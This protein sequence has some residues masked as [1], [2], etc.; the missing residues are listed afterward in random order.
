MAFPYNAPPP[1]TLCFF[2]SHELKGAV[3]GYWH[4]SPVAFAAA[5]CNRNVPLDAFVCMMRRMFDASAE[6]RLAVATEVV[7]EAARVAAVPPDPCAGDIEVV[8]HD[9]CARNA[10]E[11]RWMHHVRH[12]IPAR[13]LASEAARREM[14]SRVSQAAPG[15]RALMRAEFECALLAARSAELAPHDLHSALAIEKARVML[16]AVQGDD[17]ILICVCVGLM[18]NVIFAHQSCESAW[19]ARVRRWVEGMRDL[20]GPTLARCSRSLLPLM[21]L[22]RLATTHNRSADRVAVL[23][24]GYTY[25]MHAWLHPG[26]TRRLDAG[27][28]FREEVAFERDNLLVRAWDEELQR[29]GDAS[30]ATILLSRGIVTSDGQRLYDHATHSIARMISADTLDPRATR[31]RMHAA[32]ADATKE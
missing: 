10:F 32:I 28:Q 11:D 30:N 15:E 5:V 14:E 27:E 25:L 19:P 26:D 6:A 20:F 31:L 2:H 17:V 3:N 13:R 8:P 21:R 24:P 16:D 9:F 23:P 7:C 4:S 22:P 12:A 29:I 1:A 18:R